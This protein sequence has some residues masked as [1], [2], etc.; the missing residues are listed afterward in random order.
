V[1][2]LL[3]LAGPT[4]LAAFALVLGRI[5]GIFGAVPGIG[6]RRIPLM[7]R[8][9]FVFAVGLVLF[10]LVRQSLPAVGTDTISL[11]LLV[12]KEALVGLTFGL[13]AQAV[14]VAVEFGGQ[15]ISAQMGY[16]VAEQFD[17]EMGQVPIIATFQGMIALVLFFTFDAHHIFIRAMVESYSLVPAGQWAMTQ[18]LIRFLVETITGAF[19]LAI[20]LAAPVAVALL[21]AGVALGILARTFPQMNIFMI[22]FPL[23]I[24]IGLLVL[25]IT[26]HAFIRVLE[27]AF[28]NLGSQ[29]RT[30]LRLMAT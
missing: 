12:M 16:S 23:N 15:L 21:L 13:L 17:P 4:D 19:G 1:T 3:P 27:A 11:A 26:A 2:G 20:R 24:G 5:G 30:L 25:G 8:T 22:S 14:F 28:G 18:G 7:V 29:L 10:P 6:G 9:S